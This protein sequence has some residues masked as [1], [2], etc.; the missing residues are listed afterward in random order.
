MTT[1]HRVFS[2]FTARLYKSHANLPCALL[3]GDAHVVPK[4][5]LRSILASRIAGPIIPGPWPLK[6]WFYDILW[7]QKQGKVRYHSAT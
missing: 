6:L 4:E 7:L 2:A 5:A 1:I 3:R